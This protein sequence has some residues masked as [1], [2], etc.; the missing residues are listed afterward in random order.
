MR[1]RFLAA[2]LIVLLAQCS[3]VNAAI[4]STVLTLDGPS[5]AA[6]TMGLQFVIPGDPV[7]PVGTPAQALLS[8]TMFADIDIDLVTGVISS[9][10]LTGG[11]ML[12]T[13]WT[14]TGVPGLG[15]ISATDSNAT[16]GTVI[17]ANP[18]PDFRTVTGSTFDATGHFIRLTSGVATPGDVSLADTFIEGSGLGTITSTLNNGQHEIVFSMNVN[19]TEPFPGG[20]NLQI[21]G[22]VL[23]RTQITAIPEPSGLAMLLAI[24]GISLYRRRR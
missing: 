16:A 10:E 13:G 2:S 5:P 12:S 3:S 24:G 21:T 4:V 18:P 22:T 1:N 15:S 23:G 7:T 19:D 14:V 6:N 8:G 20:L 17:N 9:V 11:N